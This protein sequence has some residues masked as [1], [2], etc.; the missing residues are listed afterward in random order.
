MSKL[1]LIFC[2][3]AFLTFSCKKDN[4]VSVQLLESIS[5]S[6]QLFCKFEYDEQS[7]ITK[8][9]Y[10]ESSG[11]LFFTQTLTYNSEGELIL[12]KSESPSNSASDGQKTFVKSGNKIRISGSEIFELNS[13]GLP[14]SQMYSD[15]YRSGI[16]TF[17]YLDGNMSKM[18]D[19]GRPTRITTYTYDNKKSPFYNC[20]SPKWVLVWGWLFWRV[21]LRNNKITENMDVGVMTSYTYTYDDAGYALTSKASNG[22][23]I[24]YTYIKK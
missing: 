7:R 12:A 22:I 20:N 13:Q 14:I 11:E 9:I 16:L 17:E 21:D 5:I 15:L 24:T 19:Y 10:Y 4:D 1:V 3:L 18:T 8:I 6:N 2:A 23:E